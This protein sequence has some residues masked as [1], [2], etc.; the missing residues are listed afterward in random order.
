[1]RQWQLWNPEK[2]AAIV[3]VGEG[4]L[5]VSGEQGSC[6]P[7]F[8]WTRRGHRS[9]DLSYWESYSCYQHIYELHSDIIWLVTKSRERADSWR[10]I[11]N[12]AR[13]TKFIFKKAIAKL[14]CKEQRDSQTRDRRTDVGLHGRKRTWSVARRLAQD[15]VKKKGRRIGINR[16]QMRK[17][18]RMKDEQRCTIVN[19][20][21]SMIETVDAKWVIGQIKT[22]LKV[23]DI[24]LFVER[25]SR[26][27]ASGSHKQEIRK[28][29]SFFPLLYL[30]GL[31]GFLLRP[32]SSRRCVAASLY[33]SAQAS[34]CSGFSCC[35]AG[36]GCSG[37]S[38]CSTQAQ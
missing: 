36:S 1:M 14:G 11:Y 38:D 16:Q 12:P 3:P 10:K 21:A 23:W 7:I 20:V 4:I 15:W 35:E 34:S 9:C 26:D 18:W 32:F 37:L 22:L 8:C 33:C 31:G 27:I 24:H 28:V 30:L 25:K 2:V 29:L 19:D 13:K 17:K 5:W 6:L